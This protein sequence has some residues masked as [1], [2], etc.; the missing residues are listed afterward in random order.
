M[1]SLLPP[2]CLKIISGY[3]YLAW[4]GVDKMLYLST[5]WSNSR[6]YKSSPRCATLSIVRKILQLLL[7]KIILNEVTCN[8]I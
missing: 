2:Y 3:Y 4:L 6:D 7:G 5:C 8:T 1:F